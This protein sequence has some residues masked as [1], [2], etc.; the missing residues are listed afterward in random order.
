MRYGFSF[1]VS[2]KNR[3]AYAVLNGFCVSFGKN[4]GTGR[5]QFWFRQNI[6]RKTRTPVP[7]RQ[8]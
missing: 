7:A 3:Y 6:W 5:Y 4:T 2:I 1:G 8:F